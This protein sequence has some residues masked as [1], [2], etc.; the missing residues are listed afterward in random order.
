MS[1]LF[2]FTAAVDLNID[3]AHGTVGR[4]CIQSMHTV[5]EAFVAAEC[6]RRMNAPT[7]SRWLIIET[8][9]GLAVFNRLASLATG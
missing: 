7:G 9:H 1:G 6:Q 8:H 5:L 3:I 2:T 4:A